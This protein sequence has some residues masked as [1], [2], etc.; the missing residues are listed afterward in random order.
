MTFTINLSNFRAF[1]QSG[2]VRIAP[3]TILTGMNSSGKSSFLGA[4]K[5]L[6]DIETYSTS[7]G[8][9]NKDPFYFGGFEQIVNHIGGKHGQSESFSIGFNGPLVERESFRRNKPKKRQDV[10]FK[11]KFARVGTQPVVKEVRVFSSD[12]VVNI[13]V[14]YDEQSISIEQKIGG[15]TETFS[16]SNNPVSPDTLFNNVGMISFLYENILGQHNQEKA[17]VTPNALVNPTRDIR[18]DLFDRASFIRNALSSVPPTSFAGAPIRSRPN[19]TYNPTDTS[20]RAEGSHVPSQLAQLA[21]QKPS[22]WRSIQIALNNF[23][24][25]SGLFKKIDVRALGKSES[26]PFQLEVSI[27]GPKRNI[28]DVGYGVSQV[29]P[30]LFEALS[31]RKGELIMIQQP[32][33]HL[34]PEAQAALGSFIVDDLRSKSGYYLVETHSDYLID[35]IRQKIRSGDIKSEDVSLLY[36]SQD[37]KGSNIAKIEL[38]RNG[39]V[40]DPP[41]DYRD[42][43][44]KEQLNTLGF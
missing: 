44:L 9:F 17:A 14:D 3:V 40:V 28:V 11:I 20:S 37:N 43:F 22:E 42:F 4:I 27:N 5:Y 35:R 16:F 24:E 6:S 31:R 33:V 41:N 30:L 7:G 39:D 8:S 13:C 26:D 36:F 23:G 34:H 12:L 15:E 38:D 1:K 18:L 29:F 19:R 21:R 10:S 25:Q 32:E 2:D